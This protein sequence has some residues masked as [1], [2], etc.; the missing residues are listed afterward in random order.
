MCTFGWVGAIVL[1]MLHI[2][3]D[4][5]GEIWG[6]NQAEFGHT[7]IW[8]FRTYLPTDWWIHSRWEYERWTFWCAGCQCECMC[9]FTHVYDSTSSKELCQTYYDVHLTRR[10]GKLI[11]HFLETPWLIWGLRTSLN[12]LMQC[13]LLVL[14]DFTYTKTLTGRCI[15][16]CVFRKTRHPLQFAGC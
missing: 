2:Q 14:S 4:R 5:F 12:S 6:Q 9:G 16:S 3:S 8:H 10:C 15:Q 1:E 7:M 13:N 11:S